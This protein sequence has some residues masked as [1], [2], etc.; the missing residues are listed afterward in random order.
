MPDN[1]LNTYVQS[2]EVYNQRVL[3]GSKI[4]NDNY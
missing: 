3:N 4:I 1:D 2:G